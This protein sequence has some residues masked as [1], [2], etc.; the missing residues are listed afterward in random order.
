MPPTLGCGAAIFPVRG[1]GYG[2][3]ICL[4]GVGSSGASIVEL[5]RDV[6]TA[7]QTGGSA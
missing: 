6:E 4:L 2:M 5:V 3:R 7:K 1:G